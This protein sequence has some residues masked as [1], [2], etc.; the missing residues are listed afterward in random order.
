LGGAIFLCACQP[1]AAQPTGPGPDEM[2]GQISTSVALTVSARETEQVIN[3][4]PTPQAS[5]TPTP[6]LT[7]TLA[8]P[9]LTPYPSPTLP[10]SGGTVASPSPYD[11]VM[12]NKTPIDYTVFKPNKDFD[13]KFSL[14]NTGTKSWDAGADLMYDSG[15]NMLTANTIYELAAVAPG[16]TVGPFIFDAKTPK[17]EGTY[18]MVFKVQGGYCYPYILIVVKR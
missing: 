11:C 2:K 3:S 10:I 9:T 14:W 18:K 13:V 12:M 8:F 1:T 5:D 17:K 6:F 16:K 4:S 7:S 15:E